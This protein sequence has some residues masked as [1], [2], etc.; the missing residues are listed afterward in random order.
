MK[1]LEK[2]L[3]E[4]KFANRLKILQTLKDNSNALKVGLINLLIGAI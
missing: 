1:K 4:K 2:G 3:K